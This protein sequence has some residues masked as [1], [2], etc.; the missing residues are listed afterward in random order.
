MCRFKSGVI[1]KNRVVLA[2]EGND[3]HS[4]LLENLNIEDTHLNASKTFVRAE[5]VPPDGNKA[6]DIGEWKYIVDQDITPEWYDNDP[7]RYEADFRAAVKEYLKDKFIV[8][9]GHAWTPIKSDEKGTYYLLDGFLNE[10]TFGENNNYAESSIRKKLVDSDLAMKLRKDVYKRQNENSITYMDA[11]AKKVKNISQVHSFFKNCGGY[12][13]TE[14]NNG[15]CE[16]IVCES[17]MAM[18]HLENWQKNGNKLGRYLNDN[19]DDSE[20]ET[21]KQELD[22]LEIIVGENYKTLFTSKDSFLFFALFHKFTYLCDDD[23]RFALF[24]TA[25]IDELHSHHISNCNASYDD[26]NSNRA[27][28][29]KSVIIKKLEVLEHL[30]LDFLHIEKSIIENTELSPEQFIAE[31]VKMDR[32]SVRSDMDFYNEMLDDLES[33]TIKDGSKLLNPDNRLS[34]LA[35]VAYSLENEIDLDDWM[36]EYAKNNNTYF[37]DQKKNYLHMKQDLKKYLEKNGVAA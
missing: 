20:F 15:T 33:K 29:D 1:L 5:L 6:V 11:I 19:A 17:L 10:S 25:F 21:L 26:I 8:M 27:T 3:S 34:L 9:C 18:F 31:N 36:L 16:R 24:L 2:P 22:R 37:M 13:T 14:R 32:K 7:G 23:S 28:K 30:M 4:D 12:S 35:L